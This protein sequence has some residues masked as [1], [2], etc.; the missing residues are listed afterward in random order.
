MVVVVGREA[1]AGRKLLL[2]LLVKM[3]GSATRC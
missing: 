1:V 2:L 3:R